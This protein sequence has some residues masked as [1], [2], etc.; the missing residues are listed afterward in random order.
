MIESLNRLAFAD[1]GDIL[2]ERTAIQRG[3]YKRAEEQLRCPMESFSRC[4]DDAVAL[5]REHGM[6]ILT[7]SRDF[8]QNIRQFYLDRPVRLHPGVWMRITS[9]GGDFSVRMLARADAARET[10]PP[11]DGD[12]AAFC[13]RLRVTRI[14]MLFYQ[15]REKG[16]FFRGEK[17]M[18]YE[19]LYVDKGQLHSVA[20][21]Q[22]F[23]LRQGDLVIYDRDQWHMQYADQSAPCCFIN[24]SFDLEYPYPLPLVN[25]RLC[26]G[27]EEKRLLARLLSE[28][29]T[30]HL[31]HDDMLECCLKTLLLLL[32]RQVHSDAPAAPLDSSSAAVREDRFVELAQQHIAH[33]VDKRLTVEGVAR[34]VNISTSY[35][36]ALF[37]KRMGMSPSVYISRVK[38]SESKRLIQEGYHNL[39]EISRMLGYATLQH[40]SRCFKAEYGVTPS[41]YARAI[42]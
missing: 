18:P 30:P 34:S 26:A 21:G 38:L 29:E 41:E 1:Y 11:P 19:L 32:L 39:T 14:Y 40:F 27:N 28:N 35:L 7:V 8:P 24:I 13:L 4:P 3:D 10:A 33:N 17:H 16:F 31:L 2:E 36:S 15:E 20:N 37:R 9:L 23:L 5:E 25:R 6:P 22:D 12:G 42:K